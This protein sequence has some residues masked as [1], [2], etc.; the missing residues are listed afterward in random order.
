MP[1]TV[2]VEVKIG[3]VQVN[4]KDKMLIKTITAHIKNMV[5]GVKEGYKIKMKVIY[6]H[7]PITF[8]VKGKEVI[9]KNFLGEKVPRKSKIIG[10]TEVEIKGQD[11]LVSGVNKDTVG[12]T[13]SNLKL[14]TKIKKRDSR[15][16]QDGV[17]IIE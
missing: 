13:I 17:Y 2:N 4:G 3:S 15:V 1:R 14:A 9:I 8:E 16:F 5:K 10:D 6:A 12:A 11:I 7:F